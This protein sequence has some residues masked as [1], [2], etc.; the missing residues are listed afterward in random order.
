MLQKR[1]KILHPTF[2][3]E[4]YNTPGRCSLPFFMSLVSG[5]SQQTFV[6][7]GTEMNLNLQLSAILQSTIV[8]RA[9]SPFKLVSTPKLKFNL[10]YF[11][12]FLK[13]WKCF[14]FFIWVF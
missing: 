13:N 9:Y 5:F 11:I 10:L 12:L 14:K 8:F 6:V 1:R 4:V 2:R 7:E 3:F